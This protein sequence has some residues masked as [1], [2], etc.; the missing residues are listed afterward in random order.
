MFPSGMD[1]LFRANRMQFAAVRGNSGAA[2][3]LFPCFIPQLHM[4]KAFPW[5]CVVSVVSNHRKIAVAYL[6]FS[7]HGLK[8]NSWSPDSWLWFGC[9]NL[10]NWSHTALDPRIAGLASFIVEWSMGNP[11]PISTNVSLPGSIS[12]P[13][14]HLWLAEGGCRFTDGDLA[15]PTLRVPLAPWFFRDH[16]HHWGSHKKSFGATKKWAIPPDKNNVY[17]SMG[18][19]RQDPAN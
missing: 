18:I 8:H 17:I 2:S 12:E 11:R 1:V 10:I 4:S 16:G 9:K 3:G 5:P 7:F 19:S 15:S 13:D 6:G 14:T